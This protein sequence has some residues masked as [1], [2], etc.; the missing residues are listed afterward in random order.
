MSLR[1]AACPPNHIPSPPPGHAYTN[2][3]NQLLSWRALILPQIEQTSLWESSVQACQIDVFPFHNPPH[4]GYATVIPVYI[5]S[6]DSRLRS[7]LRNPF[8]DEA[9]FTSYIG[10]AGY[11]DV[12]S[13]YKPG[14]LGVPLSAGPRF[15]DITDGTS[16]TLMVAERPP[17]NSLQAGRWYGLIPNTLQIPSSGPDEAMPA[18]TPLTITDTECRFAGT[19]FGPGRLDNPCDRYHFWS[20]H[21][22]G[23]NFLFADGS[24]RFL[25]YTSRDIIPALATRAGGEVVAASRLTPANSK[26]P[27]AY[28]L[29]S[30]SRNPMFRPDR[31]FR[32]RAER[33]T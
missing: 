30:L 15:T 24:V 13:T 32:Q 26:Y 27:F 19:Q 23:A 6:T 22:G 33:L 31:S 1:T 7:A 8:G 20:L 21:I 10:V 11:V 3:P 9:A 14:V 17:P 2:D 16:Q 28:A 29:G 5:C 18:N 4:I 12:L 25:P